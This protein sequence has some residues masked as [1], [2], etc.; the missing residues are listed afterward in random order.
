MSQTAIA[1]LADT[2]KRTQVRYEAG[3]RS[4]DAEYLARLARH[5]VDIYWVI[6]G[7]KR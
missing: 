5:R 4:P 1:A 3:E 7:R 6:T 2:S